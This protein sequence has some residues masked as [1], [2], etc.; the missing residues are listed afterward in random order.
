MQQRDVHVWIPKFK[1]DEKLNLTEILAAMGL[2]DMFDMNSAD[3]SGI[4][5]TKELYVSKV[6]HQAVIDVNEEG[7]EA[8][9]ATAVVISLRCAVLKDPFEFRADRPFLFFIRDNLTNSAL[10]LGRL[11]RP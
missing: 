6:L 7:T 4:D 1:L 2:T 8:A 9:A 10:F 11:V 5:G 3:F